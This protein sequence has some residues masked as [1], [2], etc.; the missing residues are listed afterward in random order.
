MKEA[1][2]KKTARSKAAKRF[3]STILTAALCFGMLPVNVAAEGETKEIVGA[4]EVTGGKQG[5]D[6]IYSDGVLTVNNGANITIS[7]ASGETEPTSDRIVVNGNAEITLNGVNITAPSYSTVTGSAKNAIDV[8]ESAHLILNLNDDT[9]NILTG[10][11][12]VDNNGA[13]GIHVPESASLVIQGSGGVSVTGGGSNSVYGGSGIGGDAAPGTD[14]GEACGTVIILA[15][16]S[17]KISGGAG[18]GTGSGVD[19]GGGR[20]YGDGGNGQG[21]RPS[22]DGNYT[23]WGELTVPSGVEFPS[24]ITLNIPSGTTLNLPED[25]TWPENIKVTGDGTIIPDTKKLPATITLD[26][27]LILAT[28]NP[29]NLNYTYSGNGQVTIT[30]YEDEDTTQKLQGAPKGGRFY[31]IVMSAEATNLYQELLKTEK[32]EVMKGIRAATIP[33]IKQ[34]KAGNI[35]VNTVPGQKYICTTTEIEYMPGPNDPGW[36]DVTGETYTFEGLHSNKLYYIATYWPENEYYVQSSPVSKSTMTQSATYTVTIPAEPMTAGDESTVSIAVDPDTFDIGYGGKVTVSAPAEVTLTDVDTDE[37]LTSALLVNGEKHEASKPV[38]KF[39]NAG[40]RDVE[41]S[42][43][44]PENMTKAGTYEGKIEFT[45]EYTE[46]GNPN[47]CKTEEKM[48]TVKFTCHSVEFSTDGGTTISSQ[49]VADGEKIT[50]PAAPT[51]LGYTFAGW[52]KDESLTQPWDFNTEI[53]KREYNTL[54]KV[55]GKS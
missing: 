9:N 54:R 50:E 52:F 24:G 39:T 3:L 21:I 38:A 45:V 51:K 47:S 43:A 18:S 46:D 22:S 20:G 33:V 29:I 6:Y 36:I 2:M 35:T 13:S 42:F 25:F 31:W 4:F 37:E 48:V 16:G 12:G 17:I 30:W 41:I 7:M 1:K 27:D 55:D 28:G 23:V 8:S 34:A 11:N 49:I 5:I 19:I 14:Y 26:D 44:L 10:G 40:D 53:V 15:T 32:V